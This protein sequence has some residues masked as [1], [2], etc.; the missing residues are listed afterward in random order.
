MHKNQCER[1]KGY[2]TSKGVWRKGKTFLNHERETEIK[3]GKKKVNCHI[4]AYLFKV[5][6][7]FVLHFRFSPQPF[8]S[9]LS[10]LL[11]LSPLYINIFR[12]L[13]RDKIKK[14]KE[15]SK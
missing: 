12:L 2:E 13:F 10:L 15:F 5:F 3:G 14:K 6:L 9:L 4:V 7:A 11:S 8:L 1:E